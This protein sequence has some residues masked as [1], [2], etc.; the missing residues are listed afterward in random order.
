MLQ[1]VAIVMVL[2]WLMKRKKK[3]GRGRGLGCS[4][5]ADAGAQDGGVEVEC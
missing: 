5:S 1:D 4:N 2:K 3:G